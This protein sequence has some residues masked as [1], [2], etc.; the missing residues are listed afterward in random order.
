MEKAGRKGDRPHPHFYRIRSKLKVQ[1]SG[2]FQGLSRTQIVFLST[3]II[4]K[5]PYSR[6]GH[7]KFRLQ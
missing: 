3:K 6:H 4:D 1:N 5:K 2:T 7:S